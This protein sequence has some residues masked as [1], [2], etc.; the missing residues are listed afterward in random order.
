[1][2]RHE[3][4][5]TSQA[6]ASSTEI[7]INKEFASPAE[8]RPR[9]A[10]R[11]SLI[12]DH[13]DPEMKIRERLVKRDAAV[14]RL[15]NGNE[16]ALRDFD[17]TPKEMILARMIKLHDKVLKGF[18]DHDQSDI[19]D[20]LEQEHFNFE[21]NLKERLSR[22]QVTSETLKKTDEAA[23][24]LGEDHV[25]GVESILALELILQ[26]HYRKVE[27]G[28]ERKTTPDGTEQLLLNVPELPYSADEFYLGRNLDY[29]K[30]G[31]D[32]LLFRPNIC[33][34]SDDTLRDITAK[35]LRD[36]FEFMRNPL[37]PE[38]QLVNTDKTIFIQK[39]A[40]KSNG[41]VSDADDEDLLKAS[42]SLDDVEKSGMV[43]PWGLVGEVPIDLNSLDGVK[44]KPQVAAA[45]HKRIFSF[46]RKSENQDPSLEQ[47][48]QNF[49]ENSQIESSNV[50]PSGELYKLSD[51]TQEEKD[52]LLIKFYSSRFM[53][54]AYLRS[55]SEIT[56]DTL[57]VF[58]LSGKKMLKDSFDRSST[59]VDRH[60]YKRRRGG[61]EIRKE[62]REI[63]ID[64]P[65][66]EI[67]VGGFDEKGLQF[68]LS[69][70]P[71]ISKRVISPSR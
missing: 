54:D 41:F 42:E 63:V 11:L 20:P 48:L 61:E 65:P 69:T 45:W 47:E 8:L 39:E 68:K 34:F 36:M 50:S 17:Q 33:K 10:R 7:S 24:A 4:A 57:M 32:L 30:T 51:L 27:F 26:N 71:L 14:V 67:L 70:D 16:D 25:F 38:Q 19:P 59:H 22:V 43:H 66:G 52:A 60:Q 35:N 18:G 29:F 40:G 53:R 56:W 21:L 55:S 9:I 1:M 5:E 6:Q 31:A 2:E 23:N 58:L 3:L 44:D 13:L 15:K 37:N 62:L 28:T 12:V 46:G 64:V 49:F